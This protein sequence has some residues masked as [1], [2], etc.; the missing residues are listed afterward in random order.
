MQI[1]PSQLLIWSKLR[2]PNCY[3]ITVDSILLQLS[4]LS[5]TDDHASI[6]MSMLDLIRER[7]RVKKEFGKNW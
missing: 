5:Q 7:E 4:P 3:N 1:D 6:K 2:N